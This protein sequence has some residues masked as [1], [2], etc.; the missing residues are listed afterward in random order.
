MLIVFSSVSVS[1]V[2]GVVGVAVFRP[3]RNLKKESNM[4]RIFKLV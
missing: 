1:A 2:V 4:I 3:R